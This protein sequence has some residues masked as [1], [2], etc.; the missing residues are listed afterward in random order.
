M[1]GEIVI[2]TKM[3]AFYVLAT[4]N[5]TALCEIDTDFI[6]TVLDVLLV[7]EFRKNTVK[8]IANL[9]SCQTAIL[10]S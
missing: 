6:P 10:L 3:C 4:K 8:S 5:S 1:T 2:M 9:F 7:L